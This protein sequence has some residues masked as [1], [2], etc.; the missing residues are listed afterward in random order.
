VGLG[1]GVAVG[2]GVSVGEGTGVAVATVWEVCGT[3]AMIHRLAT[4]TSARIAMRASPSDR[5]VSRRGFRS[6][7]SSPS[8]TSVQAE[9][10]YT[11]ETR[12]CQQ[13]RG[14]VSC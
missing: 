9:H 5:R 14:S 6:V 1:V 2:L 4:V 10:D 13:T 7:A 3:V 12:H 11:T 8:L